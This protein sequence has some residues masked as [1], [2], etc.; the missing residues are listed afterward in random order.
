[1]MR[2]VKKLVGSACVIVAVSLTS[3]FNTS[4]VSAAGSAPT[5]IKADTKAGT[6]TASIS[7][8]SVSGATNYQARVL[9][10]TV[11]IKTTGNLPSTATSY[12]FVGLEYN[13]PV[14]LQVKTNTSAWV[15][16]TATPATVT[17]VAD[18]PSAP[19][20]PVVTVLEDAKIKATWTAPSSNGGS[21]ISKYSVQLM[22]G[23][24]AVGDPIEVSGAEE[25]ELNTK[26]STNA[27]TVTVSA[28]NAASLKSDVSGASDPVIAKKSAVAMVESGNTNTGGGNNQV[29][30][31]GNNVAVKTPANLVSALPALLPYSKLVTLKS[32]TSKTT[33]TKLSGLKVPKGAKTSFAISGA[34]KKICSVKGSGVYMLKKGTCSV[35]FTVTPKKGKKTS[36]T[37]KLILR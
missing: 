29:A 14:K 12:T 23:T 37:V 19:A 6:G 11:A 34:S 28:I 15:D 26:D 27:F 1:M 35:T 33:L 7:W 31:G 3:A 30:G 13:V 36:R 18:A 22:K 24:E 5:N 2:N 32:T 20:P 25:V 16:G 21:P 17:P 10:G 9:I 8:T 4:S